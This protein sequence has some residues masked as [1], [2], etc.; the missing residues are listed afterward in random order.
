MV[1]PYL[2]KVY[3][4]AQEAKRYASEFTKLKRTA[5]KL[6]VMCTIAPNHLVD[7]VCG[8]QKRHPGIE[9]EIADASA[10]QLEDSWDRHRPELSPGHRCRSPHAP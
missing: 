1:K 6:G 8:L 7:L 10:K 4:E 5:L 3:T 2:E 9:L